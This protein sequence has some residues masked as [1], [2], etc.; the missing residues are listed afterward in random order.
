MTDDDG[1][2]QAAIYEPMV[3]GRFR[4]G[5]ERPSRVSAG[6]TATASE[7]NGSHAAAEW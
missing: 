5:H 4:N 1:A 2:H 3:C 7:A 6:P